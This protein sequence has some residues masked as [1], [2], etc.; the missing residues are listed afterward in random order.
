ML[1]GFSGVEEGAVLG[2]GAVVAEAMHRVDEYITR[3]NGAIN[4]GN[5]DLRPIVP[6]K[7]LARHFGLVQTTLWGA[8]FFGH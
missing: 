1:A 5:N 2:M 7:N 3:C 4:I 8:P 6:Q